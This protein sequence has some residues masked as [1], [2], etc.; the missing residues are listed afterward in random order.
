MSENTNIS[1]ITTD[2][3][4]DV[5]KEV[6]DAF[7]DIPFE[8]SAF[9]TENFVIAGQITPERAYRAIGLRMNKKL[10]AVQEALIGKE[11]E[12]IEEEE[13]RAKLE[14]PDYNQFEKRKFE[15]ELQKKQI[16]KSFSEKLLNDAI[17]EL[18]VLYKHFKALP[19]YTR[20]EFEAG[21]KRHFLEK[22]NREALE[23]AGAKESL[24]NMFDDISSIQ[25]FE[26]NFKL[27]SNNYDSNSLYKL[28][29]NTLTNVQKEKNEDKN[30]A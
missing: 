7:Y 11:M 3:A 27:V 15:L 19:K 24:I 14:S 26:E 5:I 22:L 4:H 28:T 13:I 2:N 6:Q 23:L 29:E 18:N 30:N 8:N 12:K 17:K 25:N 20:E 21:E 1:L 9:Q 10:I 16:S